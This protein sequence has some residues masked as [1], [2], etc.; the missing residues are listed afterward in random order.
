MKNTFFMDAW[1]GGVSRFLLRGVFTDNPSA[2]F[3]Q[4]EEALR[5]IEK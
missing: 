1:D 3:E 2:T 4:L 5:M